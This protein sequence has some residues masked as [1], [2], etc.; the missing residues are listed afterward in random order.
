MKSI[1]IN[2]PEVAI[3]L[4]KKEAKFLGINPSIKKQSLEIKTFGPWN[5]PFSVKGLCIFNEY[6]RKEEDFSP[7]KISVT[8]LPIRTMSNPKQRGY[9]L[10]GRV[11]IQ[12]K[13]YSAYTSSIMFIIDG[14]LIEVGCIAARYFPFPMR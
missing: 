8:L 10:E 13:K 6:I 3:K 14:E 12:G 9:E 5:I 7:K 11:S 1:R 2:N 4:T